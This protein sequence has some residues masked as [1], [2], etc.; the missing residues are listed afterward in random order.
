MPLSAVGQDVD[1]LSGRVTSTVVISGLTPEDQG[2]MVTCTADNSVLIQP[3]TATVLLDVI[4]K[5]DVT[6]Q[7]CATT[8]FAFSPS[9]TCQNS[10]RVESLYSW[11]HL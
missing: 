4:G 7:F 9:G 1:S 2:A 10:K 8:H 3:Q 5:C 11:G 6:V